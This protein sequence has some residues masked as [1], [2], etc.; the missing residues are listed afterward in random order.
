MHQRSNFAVFDAF[1]FV[2]KFLKHGL[3]HLVQTHLVCNRVG[4]GDLLW[5]LKLDSKCKEQGLKQMRVLNLLGLSLVAKT[6]WGLMAIKF[7]IED[8][9]DVLSEGRLNHL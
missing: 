6:H 2:F 5:R 1:D 4:L 9:V 8:M 3:K 7:S